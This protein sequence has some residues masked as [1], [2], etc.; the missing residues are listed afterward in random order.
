MRVVKKAILSSPVVLILVCFLTSR[1][2]LTIIGVVSQGLLEGFAGRDFPWHYS[3]H[4]WLSI[5]AIWDS[6]WYLDIAKNG[7]TLS[8]LSDLPKAIDP[9]QSNFGFFPLYPL[10]IGGIGKIVGGHLLVCGIIVSNLCALLAAWFLYKLVL[11]D[12]DSKTARRAVLFLFAFP[13]SFILSGVF[14]ESLFLLLSILLFY[15]IKKEFFLFSF[16]CGICLGLS[17]PTAVFAVPAVCLAYFACKQYDSK[18]IKMSILCCAGI[19]IGYGVFALFSYMVTGD[20]S[21]YSHIKQAGWGSAWSNPLSLLAHCLLSRNYIVLGNGLAAFTG[22]IL[23]LVQWK[24]VGLVYGILGLSFLILPLTA[25]SMVIPGIMRYMAAIF[26]LF[27]ACAEFK[28][29]SLADTAILMGSC[30]LQGFL[31]VVWSNG[32]S[33]II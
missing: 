20:W 18:K 22:C 7:Y 23:L 25:G 30:L 15:G 24:R 19:P 12:R 31:M 8:V 9:H 11:I 10:I 29:G 14:A 21:Y 6:G 2:I 1:I 27:I 33:F 16:I 3:K 17:R 4:A 13:T 26:P 32:F 28:Q 5:W